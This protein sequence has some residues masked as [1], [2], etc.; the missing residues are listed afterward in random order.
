MLTPFECHIAYDKGWDKKSTGM[1]LDEILDKQFEQD[2]QR[3]YTHSGAHQADVLF[4]TAGSKAK[5]TLSRGQQ[6]VVLIALK[7]A[8]A[9]LLPD[10][11]TYLFDDITTELDTA[12]VGRF[13]E[14]I[15]NIDGQFFFTSIEP[16]CFKEKL[17]EEH[18]SFFQLETGDVSRETMY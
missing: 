7:L 9:T 3:Q 6:K 18:T 15:K 4:E 13:F 2:L 1:A 16:G 5:L 14:V 11:C 10:A 8:Q 17:L 12:H